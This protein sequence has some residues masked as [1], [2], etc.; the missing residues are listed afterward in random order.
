VKPSA[1]ISLKL[2]ACYNTTREIGSSDEQAGLGR[3]EQ[4]LLRGAGTFDRRTQAY[5]AN[6]SANLGAAKLAI[7]SGL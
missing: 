7:L 2:S 1:D 5:S 4:D 3:F 6:L